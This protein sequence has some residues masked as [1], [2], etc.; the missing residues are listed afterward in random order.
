LRSDDRD[1]A[2][3]AIG[4]EAEKI[5]SGDLPDIVKEGLAIV[6]SGKYFTWI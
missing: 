2:F 6:L 3:K 1:K 4:D 5:N